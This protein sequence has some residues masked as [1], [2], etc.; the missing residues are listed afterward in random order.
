MDTNT[1]QFKPWPKIARLSRTCT[2]TEKIDGTNASIYIGPLVGP[3]PKCVATCYTENVPLGMWAGSRTRWITPCNDNY[4]FA[5]WARNNA[6]ELFKLG[7]GHHFGEWW[8]RGI[9]RGYGLQERRFSLFNT[10]R[11]AEH[12][13][14]VSEGMQNAPACCHVVPVLYQGTFDTEAIDDCLWRLRTNG[15]VAVTG[16]MNPE[17]LVVYH[18]AANVCFKKTCIKD[19]APKGGAYSGFIN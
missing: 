6:D 4:G 16:Y 18:S 13:M 7:E 12:D 5:Q 11:W 8:G 9:Q 15:S 3:D 14:T 17:G 10:S 19:E 2:V 1:L